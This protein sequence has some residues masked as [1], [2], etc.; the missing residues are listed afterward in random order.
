MALVG[1]ARPAVLV[2]GV[3]MAARTREYVMAARSFG[4][5]NVHVLWRH[6][7]P[8]VRGV[9][10]TQAAILVPQYTLA[11]VTLSFF[12][13]GVAEPTPSWGN[14]VAALLHY[15]VV[16]SYWWMLLPAAALVPVFLLFYLLADQFHRRT[17]ISL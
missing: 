10:L 4:A 5:S 16:A 15:H 6:V 9:A 3:V 7:L 14:V 17:A 12:G 11:E 8:H 13:L 1:W 2:R